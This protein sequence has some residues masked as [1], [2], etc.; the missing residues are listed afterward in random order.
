MLKEKAE[1][2]YYYFRNKIRKKTNKFLFLEP[3][4]S[5]KIL[6]DE[7]SQDIIAERIKSGKPFVA[8]RFGSNELETIIQYIGKTFGLRKIKKLTKDLLCGIA[9]FFPN[10]DNDI[11]RFCELMI[12]KIQNVDVLNCFKWEMED[13]ITHKYM[14]KSILASF[15]TVEPYYMNNPWSKELEGKKVLVVHP[16]AETI[17]KQYANREHLFNNANVLP[18]FELITYRSVQTMGGGSDSEKFKDWF[19]ALNHMHK[20][21]QNIDY[22]IA[23]IGCG[24][25]GMPLS[26]MIKEDGKQAIHMGGALQ[27]LFGIKGKRW[28]NHPTISKLYNE[29][30]CRPSEEEKPKD[31]KNFEGGCYW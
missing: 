31:Y 8:C 30:W 20:E 22:D 24:S 3:K 9:G 14:K 28:D 17:K 19:E 1:Y 6:S 2:L 26:I 13:Y 15:N 11:D 4:H 12:N 7:S 10:S 23:L 25:Y 16:F 21:I 27:I 29:Y 5:Y 18:K